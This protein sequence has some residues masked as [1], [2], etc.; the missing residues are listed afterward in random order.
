MAHYML[1]TRLVG[2]VCKR[3]DCSFPSFTTLCRRLDKLRKSGLIHRDRMLSTGEYYY[4]LSKEGAGIVAAECGI[5]TPRR[6]LHPI[7]PLLQAHEFDLSRYW[8]KFMDDCEKL[9]I[10]V[11]NFWRDGQFVFHHG[12]KKLIP[13]G[14]I[15]V[16]LRGKARVFFVEMDRSTQTSGIGGKQ[17]AVIRQKLEQYRSLSRQLAWHDDLCPYHVR[18]MQLMIVCRTEARL[19]NLCTIAHDMGIRHCAATC[20]L[21]LIDVSNPHTA[22]G[23]QY[24]SANM[25]AAPLF[26]FPSNSGRSPPV[27]LFAR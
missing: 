20:W 11:L 18:S 26:S 12:N 17:Q 4:W 22:N 3:N 2:E 27:S 23:W 8:I 1:T 9:N 14:G 21:R 16:R 7:K 5:D 6:A 25:L 15:I 13:D 19:R 24:K 10:P